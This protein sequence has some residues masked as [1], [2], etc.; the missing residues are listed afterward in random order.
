M[1]PSA[2][3]D[4]SQSAR[5][6]LG[7]V[8]DALGPY[9]LECY[10]THYRHHYQQRIKDEIRSFNLL[11]F[12][13]DETLL[14][15][16]DTQAVF[17]LIVGPGGRDIFRDALGYEGLRYVHELLD[18][19]NKVA[20]DFTFTLGDALRVADTASRLLTIAGLGG[21]SLRIE[22]EGQSLKERQFEEYRRR[23]GEDEL[24]R[25]VK[26]K[27]EEVGKTIES[28]TDEQCAI[29]RWLRGQRRAAIP[30][31][32][33]SGKT[34]VVAHVAVSYAEL[35][36]RTLILCHNPRLARWLQHLTDG[37]GVDVA[38]F[39]EWIARFIGK[40]KVE[41][42]AAAGDL[43]TLAQR[44]ARRIKKEKEADGW[45]PH[46]EPTDADLS[47]AF[48]AAASSPGKYDVVLVDEGQDFRESWWDV[49]EAALDR[50]ETAFLYVFHDDNQALLPH[51]SQYPVEEAP[52]SLSKN[53]RN[54]G[55]IFERLRRFHP[56]A[57]GPT[58]LLADTGTANVTQVSPSLKDLAGPVTD[59]VSRVLQ[60]FSAERVVVLTNEPE[61]AQGS[62]AQGLEVPYGKS[63]KWQPVVRR[64]LQSA[65]DC[66]LRSRRFTGAVA[67]AS[68]EIE[69]RS[70]PNTGGYPCRC[71]VCKF[72]LSANARCS[73]YRARPSFVAPGWKRVDA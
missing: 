21:A 60:L 42:V 6:V 23:A 37:S 52:F 13:S 9:V 3:H 34:L 50:P 15:G 33:G 73:G 29:I 28:L 32:A 40:E 8:I 57:P 46:D 14:G 59:A 11:D 17:D 22:E 43:R 54:A 38:D 18:S 30:G 36:M 26:I 19:R 71:R 12:T 47:A 25:Q 7:L 61:P 20:H 48:D 1:N 49:I 68:P 69:L 62:M 56:Q 64:L 24:S 70:V 39:A 10:R 66:C 51:R 45:T 5:N 65:R 2:S 16:L 41:G 67:G 44:V 72:N 53:C 58:A 27:L 55:R 4:Y 63:P 31:C 35:G